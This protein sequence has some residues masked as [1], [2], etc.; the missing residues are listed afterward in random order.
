MLQDYNANFILEGKVNKLF[1]GELML[2][3]QLTDLKNK[4]VYNNSFATYHFQETVTE[5]NSNQF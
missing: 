2:R 1:D 5:A 4:N 3:I